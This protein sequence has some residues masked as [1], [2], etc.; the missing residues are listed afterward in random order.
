MAP[1]GVCVAYRIIT[2]RLIIRD[3][4]PGGPVHMPL[5]VV[6]CPWVPPYT[7]GHHHTHALCEPGERQIKTAPCNQQ[8]YVIKIGGA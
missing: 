1:V 4:H 5:L 2:G 6:K 8:P 7:A 3:S